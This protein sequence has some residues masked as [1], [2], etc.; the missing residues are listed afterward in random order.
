VSS[1]TLQKRKEVICQ[2]HRVTERN[3][4]YSIWMG[5]R[6]IKKKRGQSMILGNIS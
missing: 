1:Y 6:E 5:K 2:A 3:L 4:L